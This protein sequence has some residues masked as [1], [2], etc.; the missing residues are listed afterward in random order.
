[1]TVNRNPWALAEGPYPFT[2]ISTVEQV[3][4]AFLLDAFSEKEVGRKIAFKNEGLL[5]L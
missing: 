5:N 4:Q 3:T 1:M 2:K